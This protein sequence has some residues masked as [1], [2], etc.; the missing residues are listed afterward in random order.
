MRKLSKFVIII[1]T[2]VLT[3]LIRYLPLAALHKRKLPMQVEKLLFCA[4]LGILAAM[5]AQSIFWKDGQLYSGLPNFYLPGAVVS[6]VLG[7]YTK[8]LAIVI[9]GGVGTVALA[10]FVT[11]F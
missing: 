10:T 9:V 11:S 3:F 4:P 1:G 6:I 5:G 2:A 8:N 7:L